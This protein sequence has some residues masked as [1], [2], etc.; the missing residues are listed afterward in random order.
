MCSNL[1][2]RDDGNGLDLLGPR[3][4]DVVT[5]SVGRVRG[6]LSSILSSGW[7][8][9]NLTERDFCA[10][11]V[12]GGQGLEVGSDEAAVEGSADIVRMSLCNWDQ[13]AVNTLSRDQY[14][15]IMRQ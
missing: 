14:L 10:G 8:R 13:L 1:E 9:E 12:L 3:E 7:R 11:D 4:L 2:I 6:L 5:N 15:P